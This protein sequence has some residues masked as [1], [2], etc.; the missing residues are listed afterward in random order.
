[1]EKKKKV[2]TGC[3]V[4]VAGVTVIPVSE[5]S[6]N[7]WHS[8]RGIAF[9]GSKQP[10]SVLIISPSGKRVFRISGEEITFDQFAGEIPDITEIPG[11][12]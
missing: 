1:M 2:T 5:V 10:V 12:A 9:C 3:P 11:E 6:S 4:T 7:C 8:K